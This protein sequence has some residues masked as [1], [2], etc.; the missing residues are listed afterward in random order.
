[1]RPPS[2]A[3]RF[4]VVSFLGTLLILVGLGLFLL[5]SVEAHFEGSDRA[6][7]AGALGHLS[8]MA[9]VEQVADGNLAGLV[10]RIGTLH[11][12]EGPLRLRLEKADGTLLLDNLGFIPPATHKAGF[13]TLQVGANHFRLLSGPLE[14]GRDP[15]LFAYLA[16]DMGRHLAFL[17]LFRNALWTAI[18]IALFLSVALSLFSSRWGLAPL[19]RMRELLRQVS[20]QRLD[21]RLSPDELPREL[22]GLAAEFN[23]MLG[24]LDDAFR[25]LSQ[26]SS[27]IAH[28]L[29]TPVTNLMTQ[30]QVALAGARD[31]EQYREVLYSGLEE[32]ERMAQMIGDML[33]LAQADN[34]QL[35]PATQTVDLAAETRGLFDYFEA[36]AE[37]RRV[38]LHLEGELA[39]P[40]DRLMLRRALSN[41]LS[42][43]VRHGQSGGEVRVELSAESGWGRIRV[44][45]PSRQIPAE[46]LPRL[47]D[48]FYRIDPSRQ[49]GRSASG[50]EGTGLGL[51]IVK[52]IVEA[53]GG[54]ISADCVEG[55][56]RFQLL[57]PLNG[58]PEPTSAR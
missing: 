32:Y 54:S 11:L 10:A 50:G 58:P 4:A 18:G 57:L 43:A 3:L 20:G 46:H 55:R 23:Q 22:H 29:R 28:E 45:N 13:A 47:F 19:A 31:A 9:S 38:S 42:N 27:D 5:R 53:H 40:G 8:H 34:G 37:E 30:T 6:E 26:F 36:W 16:S 33:F 25:R 39:V 14:S 48:R 24:R 17:R 44:E 15:P 56:I 51:A 1:M 41:L 7:L 35:Q 21:P 52:S 12:S 2:L 49:R